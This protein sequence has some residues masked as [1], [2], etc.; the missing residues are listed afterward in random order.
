MIDVTTLPK[1]GMHSVGVDR[2]YYGLLGKKANR[3]SLVSLTLA[4]N[5]VPSRSACTCSSPRNWPAIQH[6]LPEQ[7]CPK[8]LARHAAR[9]RLLWPNSTGY[10]TTGPG[11]LPSWP[12]RATAAT[13]PSAVPWM[14]EAYALRSASCARRRSTPTTSPSC[15]RPIAH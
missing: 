6:A 13:L 8:L 2:Q 9:A 12:M 11:S 3:Q 4:R 10:A 7:A 15:R 5:E 14:R 1:Q